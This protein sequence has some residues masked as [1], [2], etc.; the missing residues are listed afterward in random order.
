MGSVGIWHL[1]FKWG[2]I[3]WISNNTAKSKLSDF[4]SLTDGIMLHLPAAHPVFCFS[5]VM[6]C[7]GFRRNVESR[8]P[9]VLLKSSYR[10]PVNLQS[11]V[12]LTPSWLTHLMAKIKEFF[13]LLHTDTQAPNVL[14]CNAA[15]LKF[16]FQY[17]HKILLKCSH[18]SWITSN[19]N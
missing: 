14:S 6:T 2:E 3:L 9:A 16:R 11:G 18:I 5:C 19:W 13:H 8:K 10:H 1:S 12:S 7:R 15:C 4:F 17:F